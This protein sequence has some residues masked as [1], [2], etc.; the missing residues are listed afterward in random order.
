[1]ASMFMETDNIENAR[2]AL[3]E[4]ERFRY[5]TIAKDIVIDLEKNLDRTQ[6]CP[7]FYIDDNGVLGRII[8]DA[9]HPL[10]N[11]SAVLHGIDRPALLEYI[12]NA[13][14]MQV[15]DVTMRPDIA[16]SVKALFPEFRRRS[17]LKFEPNEQLGIIVQSPDEGSFLIP[18]NQLLQVECKNLC[19][20]MR[21]YN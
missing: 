7:T 16:L 8:D 18:L 20:K 12:T 21:Q 19:E 13:W 11:I 3:Q 14:P 2:R 17:V 5:K 6:E 9:S 4:A 1:M 15:I 10:R